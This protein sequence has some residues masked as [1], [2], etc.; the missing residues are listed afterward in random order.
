MKVSK[1]A[2]KFLEHAARSNTPKSLQGLRDRL[3]LFLD[4]FVMRLPDAG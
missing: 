2:A 1:L 3:R 4:E